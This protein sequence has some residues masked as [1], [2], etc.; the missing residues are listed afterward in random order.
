MS[1]PSN[2]LLRSAG[3]ILEETAEELIVVN[4]GAEQ[5]QIRVRINMP[6]NDEVNIVQSIPVQPNK[7]S[8]NIKSDNRVRQFIRWKNLKK[9]SDEQACYALP[10]Y[11]EGA[12][13]TWFEGLAEPIQS[14]FDQLTTALKDSKSITAEMTVNMIQPQQ[15]NVENSILKAVSS[16]EDKTMDKISQRLYS[17]AAIS[18]NSSRQQTDHVPYNPRNNHAYNYQHSKTFQDGDKVFLAMKEWSFESAAP[19]KTLEVT[20]IIQTLDMPRKVEPNMEQIGGIIQLMRRDLPKW[21]KNGKLTEEM[22]FDGSTTYL[23][24][25]RRDA[26]QAIDIDINVTECHNYSIASTKSHNVPATSENPATISSSN[27]INSIISCFIDLMKTVVRQEVLDLTPNRDNREKRQVPQVPCRVLLKSCRTRRKFPAYNV[28][29]LS[30]DVEMKEK[31]HNKIIKKIGT[32]DHNK[33]FN[34]EDQ[35]LTKAIEHS[36]PTTLPQT[37]TK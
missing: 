33:T 36:K 16:I 12:A 7:F 35:T 23:P 30:C 2:Y 1:K 22:I 21:V 18:S 37:Q 11:L 20:N 31:N 5:N 25:R 19:H 27:D 29:C 24:S 9:I 13:K 8:G 14:N 4:L 10:F 6:V 28:R 26:L 15:S 3:L 17:I 34:K 32:E